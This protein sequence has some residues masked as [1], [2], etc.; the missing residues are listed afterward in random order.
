MPLISGASFPQALTGG[1]GN[2]FR[3]LPITLL[4]SG[5]GVRGWNPLLGQI[6]D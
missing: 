5:L 2:A 1:S 4:G 6:K 3:K